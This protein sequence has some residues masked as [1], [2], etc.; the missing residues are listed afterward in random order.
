MS[1]LILQRTL[2]SQL[3]RQAG[4]Y[5]VVTILGP[6]QAGKST[7]AAKVF[8]EYN[9][10]N[11]EDFSIYQEATEDPKGFLINHPSPL[12]IDEIQKCPELLGQVQ[13]NADKNDES[14]QFILTGSAQINL[15]DSISQSLAGRTAVSVLL[16]LSLA[17]LGEAGIKLERNEQLL[18]GFMPEIYRKGNIP[19]AE[20]YQNYKL[21]YLEK[22]I[23]DMRSFRNL[24]GFHIFLDALS[25]RAGQVLNNT[26]V[27]K[28][29]GVSS[30]T[31][32]DWISLLE[33]TYIIYLLPAWG[34][35]SGRQAVKSPKLYFIEP[36]LLSSFARATTPSDFAIHYLTGAIFENMVV[37]EALKSRYNS[38]SP[39]NLYFYRDSKGVEIDLMLARANN[40]FDLFEIKAAYSV[41]SDQT[42]NMRRFASLYPKLD[43]T[44]NVI[45]SGE[46]LPEP[47]NGVRYHNY[48][49]IAPIFKGEELYIPS[50]TRK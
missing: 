30:T 32:A 39:P 1:G 8:K 12:I 16:P 9:Y 24:R 40:R 7:T 13:V 21:N 25:G 15:R 42:C 44:M 49:D 31:I 43:I 4:T 17:E 23:R 28:L 33:T 19:P 45:Y 29:V 10:V 36:G 27:S 22:D 26:A 18:T 50:F 5:K 47:V 37:I 3:A 34:P 38:A 20:Y 2:E 35:D 14:G 6:R 11:L 48:R 41:A 46:T